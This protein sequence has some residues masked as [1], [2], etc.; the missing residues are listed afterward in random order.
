MPNPG[1]DLFEPCPDL[2]GFNIGF[3]ESSYTSL[4]L[5]NHDPLL[6]K[7]FEAISDIYMRLEFIICENI[8]PLREVTNNM[9]R[10]LRDGDVELDKYRI[11]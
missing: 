7:L 3:V 8:L 9:Q 4:L 6:L 1:S 11:T 2:P 10:N 5:P